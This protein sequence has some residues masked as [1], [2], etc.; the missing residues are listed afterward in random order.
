VLARAAASA[1]LEQTYTQV[2]DDLAK[3]LE[4]GDTPGQ[5]VKIGA[6]VGWLEETAQSPALIAS[7]RKRYAAP[8]VLVATSAD[9][10]SAGLSAPVNETSPVNDVILGTRIRGTAH[11][12][13]TTT[14][15]LVE[16]PKVGAIDIRL[17]AT[18]RSSNT[19]YQSSVRVYSDSSTEIAAVKRLH[20]DGRQVWAAPAAAR[21]RTSTSIRN[22]QSSRGFRF[23]E[24]E[25]W[26]RARQQQPSAQKVASRHAEQEA[27]GRMDREADET[28]ADANRRLDDFHGTLRKYRCVLDTLLC[29]T[30]SDALAVT[31]LIADD[32][33]LAAPLAPPPLVDGLDVAV[34]IH[35]SAIHNAAGSAWAGRELTEKK[36][37]TLC[38][39]L[40]GEVPERFRAPEGDEALS[41]TLDRLQPFSVRFSGDRLEVTMRGA[42]YRKGSSQYPAMHVTAVYKI[43]R[44]AGGIEAV[45]EGPVQIFPPGFQPGRDRL[46]VRQQ[47]L[48]RILERRFNPMFDERIVPEPI[49]LEEPWDKV[50]RL[51]LVEFAA[52][53]GWL[54]LGWKRTR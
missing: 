48:R 31:A 32:H 23:V 15:M 30:T 9:F 28:L 10:L 2:L 25:A 17:N 24:R 51:E 22:I 5:T 39:D 45:R 16:S 21:A 50:G 42:K 26:S 52:S 29:S 6:A 27:Q 44:G 34:R 40:L 3:L 12:T 33:Q 43:A 4:A 36:M 1:E 47:M 53:D 20:F 35:E 54:T 13:G 18:A 46:S 14:A 11:T 8:N 38:M 41:V 19:G 37:E 7:I 49:S